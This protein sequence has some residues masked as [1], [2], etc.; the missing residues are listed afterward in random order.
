M[1]NSSSNLYTIM[2]LSCIMTHSLEAKII[3]YLTLVTGVT[4]GVQW[5]RLHHPR[6]NAVAFSRNIKIDLFGLF[7]LIL[8]FALL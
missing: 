7:Y 3:F 4:E 6:E 1:L 5:V 2:C 8:T